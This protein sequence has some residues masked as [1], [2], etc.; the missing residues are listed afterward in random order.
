MPGSVVAI[1]LWVLFSTA[2]RIYLSYYDSY[3]KAYGSLGAVIIMMLWLYLTASALMVGG[4]I[5]SVLREQQL[6]NEQHPE[7]DETSE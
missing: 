5:N 3:N 7:L 2:F 6:E 1:V 4:A